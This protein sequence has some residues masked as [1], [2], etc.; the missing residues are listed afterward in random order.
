MGFKGAKPF[1]ESLSTFFSEES[2]GPSR[3]ERQVKRILRGKSEAGKGERQERE[4]AHTKRAAGKQQAAATQAGP[5]QT[6]KRQNTQARKQRHGMRAHLRQASR[7]AAGRRHL[8]AP[9]RG[10]PNRPNSGSESPAHTSA[11]QANGRPRQ[12]RPDTKAAGCP[13]AGDKTAA[14]RQKKRR[15]TGHESHT[16][17]TG[18]AR[19]PTPAGGAAHWTQKNPSEQAKFAFALL[20][21][22][23]G[24]VKRGRQKTL[25]CFGWHG[26]FLLRIA[27]NAARSTE[28]KGAPP[29]FI[30]C[31]LFEKSLTKKLYCFG[32]VKAYAFFAFSRSVSF[33]MKFHE[34]RH[35]SSIVRVASQPSSFFAFDTSA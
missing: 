35:M 23:R 4:H 13:Q 16:T 6:Q 28:Q 29:P 1:C 9:R 15:G 12:R 11:W 27:N 32:C 22:R 5:S 7:T 8:P 10:E 25:R 18:D 3:P 17:A 30:P 31:K 24:L 21:A 14:H 34:S 20:P 19:T 2:R 33:T 26:L